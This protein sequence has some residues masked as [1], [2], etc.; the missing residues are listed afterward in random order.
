MHLSMTNVFTGPSR[1]R[2]VNQGFSKHNRREMGHQ[3]P[4]QQLLDSSTN[5]RFAGPGTPLPAIP[6]IL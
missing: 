5:Q 4:Q 3:R 6:G 1:D 2:I